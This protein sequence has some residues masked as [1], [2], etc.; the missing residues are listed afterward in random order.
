MLATGATGNYA[1]LV[2]P[3]LAA[4]DVEVVALVHDPSKK[5]LPL[6]RGASE[7]VHADLRDPSSLDQAVSRVD[8]VFLITPAFASDA[9][10]LGLNVV[11]AAVRAGVRKVV[12]SG[13]YHPSLSLAN[14]ASTRPIEEAL[15][16]SDMKFVVLQPA[17]FMQGLAGAWHQALR[18]GT[19]VMPWSNHAAM[20]YVD[21]RD[22]ADVV[23]IGFT[24][25]LLDRGTFEL[26]APGMIDRVR[27]A[28]LMSEI[29]GRPLAAQ[30]LNS[31]T[32]PEAGETPEGLQAMFRDY[33][34]HGF[35]GGNALVLRSILQREPRSLEAFLREQA[36]T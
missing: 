19:V 14:H 15:Y 2:V 34:R 8:G 21:Y 13:V 33:D 18:T 10:T 27:L 1:G 12:Y 31:G 32:E 24:Q 9:T 29:A 11:A 36:G 30:D 6:S 7:V 5:D 28:A 22:V 3:A 23:A 35:H 16:H 26:A 4:L 17:M 25:A 20:T